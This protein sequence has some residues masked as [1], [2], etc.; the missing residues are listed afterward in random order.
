MNSP[1]ILVSIFKRRR[2]LTTICIT[3]TG[4]DA[5][6]S[7]VLLSGFVPTVCKYTPGQRSTT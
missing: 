1:Y 2:H 7:R 3:K 5:G 6:V 4:K